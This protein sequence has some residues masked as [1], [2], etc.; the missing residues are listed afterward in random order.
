G[1]SSFPAI[2][3]LVFSHIMRHIYSDLFLDSNDTRTYRY[4]FSAV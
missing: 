3:S 2:D 1:Y 4:D